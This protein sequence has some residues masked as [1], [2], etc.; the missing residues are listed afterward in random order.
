LK[1]VDDKLPKPTIHEYIQASQTLKKNG[2][3]YNKK[4]GTLTKE[5]L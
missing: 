5:N 4:K 1:G 3:I 2:A